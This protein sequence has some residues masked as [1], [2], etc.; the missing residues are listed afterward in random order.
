MR[1]INTTYITQ[2]SGIIFKHYSTIDP[3]V[4]KRLQRTTVQEMQG[5]LRTTGGFQ[6][7][8]DIYIYDDDNGDY[9]EA[10][11]STLKL[12]YLIMNP[13]TERWTTREVLMTNSIAGTIESLVDRSAVGLIGD[14]FQLKFGTLLW[15]FWWNFNS[16]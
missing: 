2:D 1:I 8:I 10:W 12:N 5:G 15:C 4:V 16:L 3:V 11:A 6:T 14:S 13:N 9:S 7:N